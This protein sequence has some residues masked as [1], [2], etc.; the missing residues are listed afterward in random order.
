MA[1]NR[2]ASVL[3]DPVSAIPIKSCPVRAIDQL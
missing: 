1:G 2:K 3:P